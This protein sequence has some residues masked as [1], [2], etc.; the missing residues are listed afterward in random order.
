MRSVALT[1]GIASGKSTIAK[2]LADAGA[3]IIDSD[4]LAREVVEPGTSGLDALVERFGESILDE[5]GALNRPALGRIIFGDEQSRF[6]VNEIIHPRVRARRAELERAVPEGT[7]IVRVIPLLVET[8]IAGDYD[9]VIC[10]DIPEEEQLRR[11]M[12][13]DHFT[14]EEA[15][16]RIRAQASREERLAAATRV[17]DNSGTL[18]ATR[19]QVDSL[20]AALRDRNQNAEEN[21]V[22][23]DTP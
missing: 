16:A 12:E 1:G 7:L 2:M 5:N 17:I 18:N 22:L 23:R 19:A 13:R 9:E 11:L 4:L 14:E 20:V 10:V 8:G 15:L 21:A 6:A 3:V